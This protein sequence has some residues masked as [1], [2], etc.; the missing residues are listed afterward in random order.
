[1]T[2]PFT[3][4]DK[5]Q[6]DEQIEHLLQTLPAGPED[7]DSSCLRDLLYLYRKEE[8]LARARQ[9]LMIID[10]PEPAQESLRSLPSAS[11]T[12]Q[13]SST[14]PSR[15][16]TRSANNLL[17]R[18]KLA[19]LLVAALLLIAALIGSTQLFH[20]HSPANSQTGTHSG[21]I[22]PTP[23]D[24]I[25]FSD[26]L[27]QNIHNWPV[28]AEDFFK[29]GAYHISSYEVTLTG[30]AILQQNFPES[31]LSYQITMQEIA[32]D[33]T[34]SNNGFGVILRYHKSNVGQT[35]IYTFYVF[36]VLNKKGASQ[37]SFY[38]YD[39]SKTAPWSEL[40]HTNAGQ[41]FHSGL[42]TGAVNTVK[43]STR[44]NSFT[45]SVNGRQVGLFTDPNALRPGQVGMQVNL[46]GTEVAFSNMVIT[47]P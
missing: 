37:Y 9:H 35:S 38:K 7:E 8:I 43:V 34:S 33:D 17:S 40:W 32:G 13:E 30:L 22:L 2:K 24:T 44:G 36:E 16:Y 27:S 39:S 10:L 19:T 41:E 14:L 26:P 46:Q 42:G 23:T 6:I 28:N 31:A 15:P 18:S 47:Q 11:I 3:N 5:N 25:L 4:L 20:S 21:A 45:F 12:L 1:M 29:N